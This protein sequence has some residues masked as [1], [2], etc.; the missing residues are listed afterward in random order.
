MEKKIQSIKQ[1]RKLF[2]TNLKTS[3]IHEIIPI[4]NYVYI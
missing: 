3:F 4:M 1:S 2:S